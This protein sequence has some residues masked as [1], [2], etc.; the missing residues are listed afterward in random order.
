MRYISNWQTF[1][2]RI[3]LIFLIILICTSFFSASLMSVSLNQTIVDNNPVIN[4]FTFDSL[5]QPVNIQSI[6]AN[7]SH[8]TLQYKNT[9][10]YRLFF[11]K[12]IDRSD[13]ISLS[14][15]I[16]LDNVTLSEF[17]S[18][19][20]EDT[21]FNSSLQNIFSMLISFISKNYLSICVSLLLFFLLYLGY[22]IIS[23]LNYKRKY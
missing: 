19:D 6:T 5:G 13:N 20:K 4:V 10:Y 11:E 23:E 17:V 2:N 7:N 3:F 18:L 21:D 22:V 1:F 16:S 8:Y 15:N 12:D 14:L 9:G